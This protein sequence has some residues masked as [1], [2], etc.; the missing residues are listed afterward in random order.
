MTLE[1]ARE[2]WIGCN[3]K[4]CPVE[5][6]RDAWTGDFPLPDIV[7][8]YYQHVGPDELY[9]FEET[10][11]TLYLPSLR[12]L[13]EF[14]IGIL[15]SAT[16]AGRDSK[17]SDRNWGPERL[18]VAIHHIC[19]FILDVNSGNVEFCIPGASR[20]AGWLPVARL[21]SLS[22]MMVFFGVLESSIEGVEMYNDDGDQSQHFVPQLIEHA[23]QYLDQSLAT[24]L[25]QTMYG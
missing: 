2:I 14:Q 10:H 17:T 9:C 23:S 22:E 5:Q 12:R 25:L 18:A 3:R 13:A 8:E 11:L 20:N 21:N 24:V 15:E 7:A 16:I 6:S 19:P 4:R 1:L